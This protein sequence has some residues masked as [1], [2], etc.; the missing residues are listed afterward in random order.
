MKS[1][2]GGCAGAWAAFHGGSR[3]GEDY[4]ATCSTPDQIRLRLHLYCNTNLKAKITVQTKVTIIQETLPLK[5]HILYYPQQTYD[6]TSTMLAF[7]YV[8]CCT[9]HNLASSWHLYVSMPSSTASAMTDDYPSM[10]WVA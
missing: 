5:V 2:N 9:V 3:R 7:Q 10:L 1:V 6:T 8:T 4:Q